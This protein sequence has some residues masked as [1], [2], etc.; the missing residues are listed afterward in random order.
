[1]EPIKKKGN[2]EAYSA[3]NNLYFTTFYGLPEDKYSKKTM[4]QNK[5]GIGLFKK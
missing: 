3:V 4:K 2:F 5:N 1:L